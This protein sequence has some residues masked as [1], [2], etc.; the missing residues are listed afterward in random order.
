MN[1]TPENYHSIEVK[2]EWLS[3]S[4]YRRWLECGA[5]MKAELDGKYT[6]PMTE[7]LMVGQYV[8][9]AVTVPTEFDAWCKAHEGEIASAKTGKKYAAF[10]KADALIARVQGDE[11]YWAVVEGCKAQ[12]VLQGE[13]GK[14]PWLYMADFL[15]EDAK[16][17]TL[18]D[19][20]TAKG[21]GDEWTIE[22]VN[23][24][25][26]YRTVRTR[27][28]WYDAAGYWRQL[29]VGRFLFHQ[30][31]SV[32]P[33]CGI[34][35]ASKPPP[36]DFL[37]KPRPCGLG[38]WYLPE[39]ELRFDREISQIKNRLTDIMA[40]KRGDV[41]APACGECDWCRSQS[42]WGKQQRGKSGRTW[43]VDE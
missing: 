18:L 8:D 36:D 26:E 24:G 29:S 42:N 15:R 4:Q 41:P 37:G 2:R 12:V 16:T 9:R 33:L 34:L 30:Q 43:T 38:A 40:W 14:V 31:H 11:L 25:S 35:A 17:A 22:E 7:A 39:G 10:A 19:F 20:K 3:H 13:I 32:F 28:P 27:V 6:P 5:A 23:M 1:I 21:F